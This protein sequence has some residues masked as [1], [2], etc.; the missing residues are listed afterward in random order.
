MTVINSSLCN[1]H[2]KHLY[3]TNSALWSC[4]E[5]SVMEWISIERLLRKMFLTITVLEISVGDQRTK[6]N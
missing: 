2:S 6:K 4:F 3:T 1:I 5:L